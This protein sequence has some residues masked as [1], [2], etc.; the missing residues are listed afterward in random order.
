MLEDLSP[1]CPGQ[2][3]VPNAQMFDETLDQQAW[4]H[5]SLEF[6]DSILIISPFAGITLTFWNTPR[7]TDI[8]LKQM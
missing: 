3:A 8:I 7:D 6:V 5:I 4:A 1:N 2:T